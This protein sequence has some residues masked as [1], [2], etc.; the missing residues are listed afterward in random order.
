MLMRPNLLS[1]EDWQQYVLRLLALRYGFE[2]VMIPDEHVAPD[3]KVLVA[4]DPG[5]LEA[6]TV[7][8]S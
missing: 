8:T 4:K 1:G 3:W 6:C 7:G 5:A 2:L